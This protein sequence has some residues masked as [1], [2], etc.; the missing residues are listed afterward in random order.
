[1]GTGFQW[2]EPVQHTGV[3][4]ALFGPS[5]TGIVGFWATV[6]L[7]IPDSTRYARSQRAQMVGQALALQA[8]MILVSFFGIAVTSASVL[9]FGDAMWDPVMLLT[10]FQSTRSRFDR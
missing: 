1:M 2:A 5:L 4:L 9:I 10:R 3:V 6:A 7:N 8:A